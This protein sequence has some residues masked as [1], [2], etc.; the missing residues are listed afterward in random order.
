MRNDDI[1]TALNQTDTIMFGHVLRMHANITL[2]GRVEGTAKIGRPI[3]T[4]MT[5]V[6]Y[7][8]GPQAL[9]HFLGSHLD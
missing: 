6:I 5:S 1:R 9:M 7:D 2:H 8:V 3:V 4:W